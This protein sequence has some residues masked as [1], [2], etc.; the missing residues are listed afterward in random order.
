[1]VDVDMP[2]RE[3]MMPLL[4]KVFQSAAERKPGTLPV[5]VAMVKVQVPEEDVMERPE[6]P[7]VARVMGSCLALQYEDEAMRALSRVPLQTGVKVRVSAEVAMVSLRF[8]SVPVAKVKLV[9]A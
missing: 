4:L 7:E 6:R 1:M 8:V 2:P 3:L 5:E 9:D